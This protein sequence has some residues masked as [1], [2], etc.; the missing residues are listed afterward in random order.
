METKPVPLWSVLLLRD[1]SR[2][3]ESKD[4]E[5]YAQH[6][7]K[8]P[9][10]IILSKKIL[11]LQIELQAFRKR[12]WRIFIKAFVRGGKQ[13]ARLDDIVA[14]LHENVLGM[15]KMF[16]NSITR[17]VIKTDKTTKVLHE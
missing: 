6:L 12:E 4:Y 14:L 10:I 15:Q 7:I 5:N 16:S 9:R 2:H 8:I 3:G 11:W 17:N 13:A 1:L